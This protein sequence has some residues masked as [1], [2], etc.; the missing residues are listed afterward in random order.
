MLVRIRDNFTCQDCGAR[1]TF[2]EVE[3]HNS[4][5][6]GLKGRIKLFDIHHIN[7]MCGK[8][9]LKYDKVSEM[10]GLITLCHSCHYK[11]PEH[12][13]HSNSFSEKAKNRGEKTRKLI[14]KLLLDGITNRAEIAR[15][16]GMH[17]NHVRKVAKALNVT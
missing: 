13:V 1:R 4:K 14:K 2:E 10:G 15:R 7:G 12:G 9:S 17:H 3:A 5:L 11:R 16:I 8:K 6:S